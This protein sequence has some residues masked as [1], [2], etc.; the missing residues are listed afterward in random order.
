MSYFTCLKGKKVLFV[1]HE[2]T[3]TGAPLLL[4]ETGAEMAASGA[5]V[6]LTSLR[7]K[8]PTFQL[9]V[10][11]GLHAVA[12]DDSFAMA[13]TADVII[14]NTAVTKSWV[15]M[16][17]SCNP[18]AAR[19]LVW[20][21]HEIDLDRYAGNMEYLGLAAAVIFDSECALRLWQQSGLLL[22]PIAMAIHPGVT[23]NFWSGAIRLQRKKWWASML[24]S[25]SSGAP[26]SA[27][28]NVR[29]ALGVNPQDFLITLAGSYCPLKGHDL[30]VD[31]VGEMLESSPNL[32]LKLLLIGFRNKIQKEA[33]LKKL[34]AR[35]LAAVETRRVLPSVS[36]LKPY[37]LA[38]DAYVMNTQLPGETFGR[39]SIEAMA[40]GLPV[41]ATDAGGTREI[42][43]DGATGLLHPPGPEG[44][45]TLSK[46][47]LM[48][49]HDR[50]RARAL[51]KAGFKRVKAEFRADRFYRE[52][53]DVMGR[54][55]A[56][57][58]KAIH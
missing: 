51:G 20:W 39:V 35:Q 6:F 11:E 30:L 31:T 16:L 25:L 9:G 36:D 58:E 44:Q 27:R 8:E 24:G 32:P 48:L 38:S 49:L 7:C 26:P 13:A 23:P 41:L 22:P 52:F 3:F 17:L 14:A 40:F 15:R 18:E 43:V 4:A 33:F 19:K 47:I 34:S 45:S 29:T 2:I 12:M 10:Y 5:E 50:A 54:M 28:E 56:V 42:V 46:H 55:V 21:I 57:K 53:A 37:Y 1:S